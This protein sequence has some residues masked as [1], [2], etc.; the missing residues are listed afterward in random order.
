MP[1]A[2]LLLLG[3]CNF[4]DRTPE[5]IRQVYKGFKIFKDAFNKLICGSD[6][7]LHKSMPSMATLMP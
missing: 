4:G 6:W 7:E 5:I 2:S 1:K 3:D